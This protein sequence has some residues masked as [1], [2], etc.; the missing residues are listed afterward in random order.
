MHGVGRVEA[1]ERNTEREQK[2]AWN[3]MKRGWLGR[4]EWMQV[5]GEGEE[6]RRGDVVR[7]GRG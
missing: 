5:L 2:A 7:G 6:W 3:I 4:V 1:R